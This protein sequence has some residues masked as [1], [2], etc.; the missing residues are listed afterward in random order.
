MWGLHVLP[1]WLRAVCEGV[2]WARVRCPSQPCQIETEL[3]EA[4]CGRAP[5]SVWEGPGKLHRQS[6]WAVGEVS[7]AEESPRGC[8]DVFTELLQY[9][10]LWVGM[11][12]DVIQVAFISPC[13]PCFVSFLCWFL[14]VQA[15]DS[16]EEKWEASQL[17]LSA[18]LIHYL[19]SSSMA[20]ILHI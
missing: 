3:W 20:K 7:A 10:I 4:V 1:L 2:R 5:Q 16:T 17:Y 12:R 15:S 18:S 8:L 13:L 11:L 19:F 14:C 9:Q 6:T